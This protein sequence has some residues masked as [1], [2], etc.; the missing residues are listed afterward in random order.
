MGIEER[1][2]LKTIKGEVGY[3]INKF[4]IVSKEPGVASH[5]L[6]GKIR[7]SSDSNVGPT[8]DFSDNDLLA[9]AFHMD[10]EVGSDVIIFDNEIFNQDV[11]VQLASASGS[12]VE[13][14]Y[15][16]ELETMALSD[17]QST[18]LTLKNLR[19]ITS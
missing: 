17:V 4:Q 6:V 11:F 9:C 14:N 2:R 13:G 7:L 15:Y 16:I 19:S 12:T 10:L 18:Q 5:E 1:I 8:I 3:K